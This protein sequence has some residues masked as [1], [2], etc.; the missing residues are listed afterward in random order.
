MGICTDKR[1]T[2]QIIRNPDRTDELE[3]YW[4]KYKFR[5][6][7]PGLDGTLDSPL[8]FKDPSTPQKV[9][10]TTGHKRRLSDT[11][12]VLRSSHVLA[13][14]HPALS[15]SDLIAT[16]GPL[17]FPLYKS[18]LLRKRILILREPPVQSTCDFGAFSCD[19]GAQIQMLTQLKY[20]VCRFLHQFRKL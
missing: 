19:A 13:S 16:F 20:M 10:G 18:A 7:T 4:D 14:D 11:T 15:L 9:N 2:R 1:A 5:Q 3:E 17:I 8:S 6:D 12:A